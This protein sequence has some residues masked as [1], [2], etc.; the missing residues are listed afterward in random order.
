MIKDVAKKMNVSA[1]K[2]EN[3]LAAYSK[4]ISI[5]SGVDN[6]NGKE[7]NVADIL[8]DEKANVFAAA[9]YEHL[10]KDIEMIGILI[11]IANKKYVAAFPYPKQQKL[12]K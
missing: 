10:K 3:Y 4:T 8:E 2:I 1:D 6:E 7:M 11:K 5:E 12:E 9:E